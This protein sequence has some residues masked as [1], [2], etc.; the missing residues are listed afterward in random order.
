MVDYRWADGRYNRLQ[1]MAA[2]L[3]SRRV[4]LLVSTG[5]HPTLIAA[6]AATTT[7]PIVFATGFDPVESGIIASFD[8]PVGNLTGV[9]VLTTGLEAKR[10]GLLQEL[11]PV[12]EHPTRSTHRTLHPLRRSNDVPMA[13]VRRRGRFN[14]LWNEPR[15]RV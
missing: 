2:D 13:R 14:E 10:F 7:I 8:R 5:G 11:V 3:I 4:A 6:K 1:T 9:H 12:A 15:R